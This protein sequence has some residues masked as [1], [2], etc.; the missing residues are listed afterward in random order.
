MDYIYAKQLDDKVYALTLHE[1]TVHLNKAEVEH[2]IKTLQ[3]IISEYGI[4]SSSPAEEGLNPK[5]PSY[6]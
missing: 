6:F 1:S 2:T 5:G 3:G 4:K